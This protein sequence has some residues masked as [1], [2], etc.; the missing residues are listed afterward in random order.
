[1]YFDALD[2]VGQ[3]WW[4]RSQVELC[5]LFTSTYV[6]I[7]THNKTIGAMLEQMRKRCPKKSFRPDTMISFSD[8]YLRFR[9][10]SI[11]ISRIKKLNENKATTR[12]TVDHKNMP[13]KFQIA[14]I[15]QIRH[16]F[17]LLW[18]HSVWFCNNFDSYK[19]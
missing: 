13:Q 19:L 2:S 17:G 11:Q 5:K 7:S 18:D 3:A 16:L 9:K 15:D 6:D 12:C 8:Q 10:D 1:M 14:S 4:F